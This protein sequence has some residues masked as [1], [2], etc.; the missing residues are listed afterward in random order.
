MLDTTTKTT[1]IACVDLDQVNL[2]AE[3]QEAP[4]LKIRFGKREPVCALVN[5]AVE[6]YPQFDIYVMMIDDARYV[7]PGWDDWL[8][9]AFDQFPNHIG[10][11]SPAHDGGGFLAY[12]VVSREWIETLG[13][14]APP[15]IHR[16]TWDTAIELLGEA[17]RLTY[18]KPEEFFIKHRLDER[19]DALQVF[20]EDSARF[21][22]WCAT[23]RRVLVQK[24]RAA[25]YA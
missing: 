5:R 23:E 15:G 14:F 3:V 22:L 6:D 24:L 13:C 21:V 11:V 1:M 17:T 9:S 25:S 16:F 10:A 4:R 12:P 7:T 18:A 8:L 19:A 2:Y 20:I